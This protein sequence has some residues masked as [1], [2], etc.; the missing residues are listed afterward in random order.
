MHSR[1]LG[2]AA[3]LALLLSAPAAA[4]E[5]LVEVTLANSGPEALRCQWQLAHWMTADALQLP[6]GSEGRMTVWREDSGAL[7]LRQDEEPRPFH[8]EALLCGPEQ[9]FGQAR[10]QVDLSALRRDRA[11][12][13]AVT[14]NSD[15]QGGCIAMPVP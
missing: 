1:R 5:E 4:D 8:I 11:D 3:A 10:R 15:A 14:C 9:S 6:A 12:G 13:L 2:L 7:F